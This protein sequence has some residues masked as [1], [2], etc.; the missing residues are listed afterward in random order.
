M[1]LLLLCVALTF[2]GRTARATT[3]GT[4]TV[5]LPALDWT[6]RSDWQN[7]RKGCNGTA[8]A[9]GDGVADDTAAIQSCID[10]MANGETLYLPPGDYKITNTLQL[11]C[12]NVTF[13]DPKTKQPAA[14]ITGCVIGGN[15]KGHGSKTR[16]IWAGA[17]N[18]TMILDSGATG[19]RSMGV[20]WDGAGRAGVGFAHQSIHLFETENVHEVEAYSG[21]NI[22][23]I[24]SY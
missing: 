19:F 24:G 13:V 6:P 14:K 21:F 3:V 7:V 2:A 4:S 23:G 12:R 22:A 16:V 5:S 9:K 15:I 8:G 10:S 18:E 1:L 20:H 11:G 17:L